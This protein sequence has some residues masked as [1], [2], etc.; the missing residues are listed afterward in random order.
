MKATEQVLRVIGLL[1]AP[2]IFAAS[3]AAPAWADG[4]ALFKEHCSMCHISGGSKGNQA[5]AIE[6][7]AQ[8]T[9]EEILRALESGP[10]VIYGNRMSEAERRAI[11]AFLSSNTSTSAALT[12]ANLCATPRPITSS[13][14]QSPANWNGWGVD[15]L[16]SRY[17][18]HTPIRAD[19]VSSLKLK[20]AF[21]IPDASTAYGQPTAVRRPLVFWLG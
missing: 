15:I 7:L 9:Q 14:L 18:P 13:G 11:A 21:G 4:A 5:P 17:Q 10:M 16:N 19:N 8:K 2:C 1:L 3:A 12:M 20:W 6:V